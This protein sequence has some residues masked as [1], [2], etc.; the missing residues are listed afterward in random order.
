[1]V[2]FTFWLSSTVQAE[3]SI[4]TPEEPPLG[5]TDENGFFTGISVDVIEEI[6]RRV[7]DHTPIQV[8][9]WARA[10]HIALQK[11]NIVLFTAARTPER[12]DRFHWITPINQNAW[13]FFEKTQVEQPKQTL[14][15]A[16]Q[17]ER[18][19]AMRGAAHERFLLNNGFTEDHIH[20]ATDFE[21][22]IRMLNAGRID[23]LFYSLIGLALSAKNAGIDVRQFRPSFIITPPKA[24]IVMSLGTDDAVVA[25]WKQTAENIKKDGTFNVIAT[26]WSA[27][28]E[29]ELSLS[30]HVKQGVLHLWGDTTYSP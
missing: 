29:Q 7:N 30:S 15:D 3:L 4:Y 19:G 21:Q 12:E 25:L 23:A 14:A 17:L 16:M 27:R 2:T 6:Q 9:P 11:P 26:R 18:I 5:Y 22:N 8:I 28:L 20:R 1:M 24:Y 10:Y 13:A